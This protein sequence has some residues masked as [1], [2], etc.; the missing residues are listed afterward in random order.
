MLSVVTMSTAS[1][2]DFGMW[3]RPAS[4]V[5]PGAFH[6]VEEHRVPEVR[7]R[8]LASEGTEPG[9]TALRQ[10]LFGR[11]TALLPDSRPAARYRR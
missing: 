5:T 1:H 11:D 8:G 6:D 3:H 9:G 2:G 7:R 10:R 4:R